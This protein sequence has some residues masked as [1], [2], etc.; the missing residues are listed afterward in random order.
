L[1]GNAAKLCA[2]ICEFSSGCVSLAISA[3]GQPG[4]MPYV[5]MF[6]QPREIFFRASRVYDEQKLLLADPINN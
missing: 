4:G 6:L 5:E 3:I 2:A 1:N